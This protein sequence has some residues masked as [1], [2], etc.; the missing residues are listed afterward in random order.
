MSTARRDIPTIG[1]PVWEIAR[2]FPVQGHWCESEYLALETNRLVEFNHGV[3]EFLS[4]PT[5][6]HQLILRFLFKSFEEWLAANGAG[7]AMFAP[8]RLRIEPE[9]YREPDLLILLDP[10]DPRIGDHYTE[11]ADLVVEIVSQ[12]NREHDTVTKRAEYARAGIA[13]YWIVDPEAKQVVVLRLEGESYVEHGVF[14]PGDRATSA[15]L[16]GFAVD[17]AEALAPPRR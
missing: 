12:S 14:A 13:E 1:E 5:F 4:M 7:I 2:L 10:N 17:A 15:L 3:I 6:L 9:M 16:E 11:H 8:Y